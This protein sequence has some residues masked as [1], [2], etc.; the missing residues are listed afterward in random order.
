MARA[1]LNP[2]AQAAGAELARHRRAVPKMSQRRLAELLDLP[3]TAI[4]RWEK[5]TRVPSA[6]DANAYLTV[7]GVPAE[8]RDRV[9]RV[10]DDAQS[11]SQL[12][13]GIPGVDKE[14]HSLLHYERTAGR[15]VDVSPLMVPG[16]LQTGDYA[17]AIMTAAEVPTSEIDYRVKLRVGRAEVLQGARPVQLTAII[18]EGVLRQPIGGYEVLRGQLRHLVNLARWDN[19][20]IRIIPADSGWTPANEAK[21]QLFEF[22]VAVPLVALDSLL[23]VMFVVDAAQ[24]AGYARAAAS[25]SATVLSERESLR[26]IRQRLSEMEG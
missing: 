2:M 13:T 23:S 26:L 22:P 24:V 14:I 8:E 21:F 6:K 20:S 17:R 1:L 4:A 11:A 3:Q 7:L 12:S 9:L 16:L 15:I 25:L 10:L 18:G 5:G 19:V